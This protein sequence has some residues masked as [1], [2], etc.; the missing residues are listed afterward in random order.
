MKFKLVA[1]IAIFAT[2]FLA[3]CGGGAADEPEGPQSVTLQVTQNDNY[4]GAT[5][6]NATNPPTWNVNAGG[7]VAIELT[8]NGTTEHNW[9][10]VNLGADMPDTFI[11]EEHSDL[12][13]R[14]TGLVAPGESFRESFVAPAEP[15]EYLVI[16]T[17]AGHYP[18]MQGKLIVQ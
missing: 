14:E 10:V 2:L 17:V 5:P 12:I 16:C 13:L 8:N 4:Y 15:G 6:D 11:E 18:S 9:A 7:Q 1:V 3:A